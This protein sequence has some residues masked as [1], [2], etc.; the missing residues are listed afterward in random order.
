MSYSTSVLKKKSICFIISQLPL[1][2]GNEFS[3]IV[4]LNHTHEMV[5]ACQTKDQLKRTIRVIYVYSVIRRTWQN[6]NG[7][8]IIAESWIKQRKMIGIQRSC[9]ADNR[10]QIPT[11]WT[12]PFFR[13]I[14]ILEAKMCAY[15]SQPD[16]PDVALSVVGS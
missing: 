7:N 15:W 8:H 14:Q 12:K 10:K 16:A 5:V 6:N 9:Y 11:S 4:K 1:C 3:P 2:K 13:I